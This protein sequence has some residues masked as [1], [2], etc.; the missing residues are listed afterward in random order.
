MKSLCTP[1][2]FWR[3][4]CKTTYFFLSSDLQVTLWSASS[5]G[6]S[7]YQKE[8]PVQTEFKAENKQSFFWIKVDQL[9]DTCLIIYRSTCF[10][11]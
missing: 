6:R 3:R 8:H 2:K 4:D 11:R 9:D 5:F 7:K 10:R 1:L